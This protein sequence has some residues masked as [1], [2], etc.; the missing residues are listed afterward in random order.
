MSHH[1]T[2]HVVFV[3]VSTEWATIYSAIDNSARCEIRAV[4][5]FLHTKNLSAEKI[6]CELCAVYGQNIT[7]ERCVRQWYRMF[8]DEHTIFTMKNEVVGWPSVVSDNLV[9]SVDQKI[10]GR[11]RFRISELSREFLQISRMGSLRVQPV[12]FNRRINNHPV[13]SNG[14]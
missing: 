7:S 12:L 13:L 4:I 8:E 11:W 3:L 9:Q 1:I 14:R 10:Y 6:H 5:R 2:G